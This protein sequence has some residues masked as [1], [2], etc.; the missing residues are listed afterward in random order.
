MSKY[1]KDENS[2]ESMKDSGIFYQI[3]LYVQ[4]IN[5]KLQFYKSQRWIAVAFIAFLY[6]IRLI[7]TGG[8]RK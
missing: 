5:D 1:F 3:S 6:L 8:K 7:M 2:E 4:S